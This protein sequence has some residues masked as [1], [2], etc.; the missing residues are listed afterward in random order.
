MNYDLWI[1]GFRD[2]F[3]GELKDLGIKDGIITYN[4]RFFDGVKQ[5]FQARE[6]VTAAGKLLIPGL[7]EAHI[8]LDK[9]FLTQRM[10]REA[11]NLTD[12]IQ[13]TADLKN[14]YTIE[15]IIERS[16]ALIERSIQ[17]GVTHL[18]CQVEVDPIIGLKSM[19]AALYVKELYRP[20]L[21]MQLV[22]F[23]Q[24]GIF[25]QEGM[26]ELMKQA[27]SM[28]GDAV[29]GIPY[30]DLDALEHLEWVFQLAVE[31]GLPVDLHVDF[32]DNP[33]QRTIEDIV[34]L[35]KKYGM[36]GKVSVAHLTSLGSMEPEEARA[37]AARMAEAQVHVITLP[38]TDL[39][40]NGRGDAYK[41]RRGLTPVRLLLEE[42]VNVCFGT[43]NIRNAF[44]P[45]GKGDPLDIGFLLAQTAYM[46][47][48]ADATLLLE[49]C[50]TRAAQALNLSYNPFQCHRAA[51]FVLTSANTVSDLI[52]DRPADRIVWKNGIRTAE[53][54]LNQFILK[55][56]P[57]VRKIN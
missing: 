24:E 54:S 32:S 2:P 10:N 38:A 55:P 15:D 34:E 52:Y 47:T 45:F 17:S 42:G 41:P 23:P 9:A 6:T 37:I 35:T 48:E 16:V 11:E 26:F 56:E 25:K 8:H 18:R 4:G 7:V 39:Y 51:D 3:T 53:I 5:T 30:N 50:T 27:I 46:G 29:G 57:M 44:T 13:I 49:M 21:D 20:F 33:E 19:E 28:G 12:A 40:L 1:S 31:R 22:V 36:E 43:N 14:D